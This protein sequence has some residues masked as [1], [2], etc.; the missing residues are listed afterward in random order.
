MSLSFNKF[1]ANMGL[2]HFKV[3]NIIILTKIKNRHINNN[4]TTI[5]T[6]LLLVN[7]LVLYL[8]NA[9]F[10]CIAISIVH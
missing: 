10:E 7:N 6:T 8:K 2:G 5:L 4:Q 3:I 9:H 1:G